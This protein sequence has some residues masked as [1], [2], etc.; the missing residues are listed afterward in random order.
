M[1]LF[2]IESEKYSLI[3]KSKGPYKMGD[4]CILVLKE[5]TSSLPHAF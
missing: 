1:V 4:N 5:K 3:D 2:D